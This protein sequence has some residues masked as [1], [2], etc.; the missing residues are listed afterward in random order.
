MLM[1]I[2]P[3]MMIVQYGPS[4]ILQYW[5]H[6]LIGFILYCT[7]PFL[8]LSGSICKIS[9]DRSDIDPKTVYDRIRGHTIFGWVYVF[10]V[11]VPMLTGWFGGITNYVFGVIVIVDLFS[12]GSFVYLKFS[13]KKI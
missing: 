7:L 10:F 6:Q 11:H 1:M 8:L 2:G 9:K 13:K 5:F 3:I 4:I 12:Y